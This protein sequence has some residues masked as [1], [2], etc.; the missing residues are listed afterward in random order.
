MGAADLV[1]GVSGGTVALIF[2]IYEELVA[3]IRSG[4]GA[5]AGVVRFDAALVKRRA[6]EIDWLW[7]L[8]L[9]V[10]IGLAIFSLASLID[11]LI[12]NHPVQ[13][14]A[15]FFGLVAA[16]IAVA[17]RYLGAP[18]A[19][20]VGVMVAVAVLAFWILGLRGSPTDDPP[21]LVV[22]G[23]GA[24]AICAMILPGI[25]G[26]FILLMLGLYDYVLDAVNQ[27]D[28]SVIA[29]FAVGAIVGLAAFS[30]VLHWLLDHHRD[31]VIAA[32][33]GL[34]AG[35]LRVLWPWPS[36]PDG[37]DEVGLG[38][39]VGSEIAGAVVI[40]VIAAIVVLVI[41]EV[42]RSRTQALGHSVERMP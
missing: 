25:S 21:L 13:V 36:E 16:S 24:L 41:A 10:G 8:S 42:S 1:P 6:G 18:D 37:L 33:V 2:G 3:T 12:E 19:F 29:V 7:L 32:L 39:P 30:T 31:T 40:A 27:R 5:L 9:L 26:S 20:R 38:R 11:R 4:A 28:Y 34:M 22:G 23:A 14:S 15:A 35:S 17:S